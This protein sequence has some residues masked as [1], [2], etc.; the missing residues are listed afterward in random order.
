MKQTEK[1]NAKIGE[2]VNFDEF[3]PLYRSV[4]Q[5][6]GL[7]RFCGP[8][9]TDLFR[10]FLELFFAENEKTNL[11]AIRALPEAVAKHVADCLLA[12]DKLPHDAAVLDLG[13][14]GG[15]PTFPL[16]IA[17]PDLCITAM[18]STGKKVDFAAKTAKT[19]GLDH[20]KTICGRAEDPKWA[21]MR[22]TFDV[23]TGRAVANLRVFA[24][25]AFPFVRVG[26][27]VLS[28]KGSQGAAELKEAENAIQTLGG[29]ATEDHACDL[30]CPIPARVTG[31]TEEGAGNA[32]RNGC[33]SA[34]NS[35]RPTEKPGFTVEGRHLILLRKE[36]PTPKQ[37]PRAYAAILKSPL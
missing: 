33:K 35:A 23:V 37:Y 8:R 9:E 27:T 16:A 32:A 24:E 18:D 15:F 31:Q 26:G 20:V 4:M 1:T 3:E 6:N 22:E 12:A 34:E 11:S 13:C 7:E 25:L 21:G 30:F 28:Y 36:R 29:T 14:G 5:A 19:L 2:N 17:R 10:R